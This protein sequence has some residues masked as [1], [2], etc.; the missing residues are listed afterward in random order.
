MAVGDTTG[1]RRFPSPGRPPGKQRE[2][3]LRPSYWPGFPRR[4]TVLRTA[5]AA[6]LLVL[7]AAVLYAHEPTASCPSPAAAS[8]T[9]ITAAGSGAPRSQ[10]TLP[11]GFVGMPVRVAEPAALAVVK[12]G[13][14]VDLLASETDGKPRLLAS[15][16]LVLDVVPDTLADGHHALYL[17]LRP[18]QARAAAGMPET[19]RFTILVR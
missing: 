2:P 18:D 3:T 19:T 17:A 12:P 5:S 8:A 16:A 6:V 7:A 1:R 10:P 13:A 4:G 15:E 14:R 11:A 9:P